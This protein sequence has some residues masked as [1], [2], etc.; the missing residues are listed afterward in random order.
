M[1]DS[2]DVRGSV[3]RGYLREFYGKPNMAPAIWSMAKACMDDT[4]SSVFG[5]KFQD[6][7]S[8]NQFSLAVLLS[9]GKQFNWLHVNSYYVVH[10]N[11]SDE[12]RGVS[13]YSD[14][15]IVFVSHEAGTMRNSIMG[16]TINTLTIMRAPKKTFFY[17]LGG[18]PLSDLVFQV[19]PYAQFLN[20]KKSVISNGD[21]L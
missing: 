11:L 5:V 4:Q 16:Q 15:D 19:V 18:P 1:Q 21:S 8:R 20:Q 7:V 12:G 17:D 14:Y 6:S 9:S 3:L 13:D 10:E 2:Y